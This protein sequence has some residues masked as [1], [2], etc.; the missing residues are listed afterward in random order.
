MNYEKL[1][2]LLVAAFLLYAL[3]G[4]P[5]MPEVYISSEYGLR[6]LEGKYGRWY[7]LKLD[8]AKK[9]NALAVRF[10]CGHQLY[11]FKNKYQIYSLGEVIRVKEDSV[12][13]HLSG[14]IIQEQKDDLDCSK[15]FSLID[16]NSGKEVSIPGC[17]LN[18][19][20]IFT[21]N[22][23]C[24]FIIVDDLNEGIVFTRDKFMR[25]Y[26]THR[27]IDRSYIICE[28]R[29]Y[30]SIINFVQKEYKWHK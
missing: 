20:K 16:A 14:L 18:I 13:E 11:L 19:D 15:W 8:G 6:S 22:R 24:D 23:W 26:F 2:S 30:N 29:D 21:E 9:P 10:N 7:L 3:P 28:R 12:P 27:K 25:D 4:C 1:M 17:F 5:P